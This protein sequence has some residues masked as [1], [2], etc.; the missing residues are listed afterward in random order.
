MFAPRQKP[1]SNRYSHLHVFVMDILKLLI[2]NQYQLY[3][4]KRQGQID[5]P[6]KSCFILSLKNIMDSISR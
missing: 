2:T 5:S 6:H 4:T 1:K 3:L